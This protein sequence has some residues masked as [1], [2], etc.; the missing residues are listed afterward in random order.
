MQTYIR[1]TRAVLAA[2]L[3]LAAAPPALGQQA[4]IV[5][6]H[7]EKADQ[8]TDTALS[9]AGRARAA[10]L[11]ALL[12]RAGVTAVYAT[13]YRRTVQTVQPL[14]DTLK[15]TVQT[16]P[17]D[18]TA[19]LVARLRSQHASDVVLVAGH[20]NSVPEILARLGHTQAVTIADDDFS[21]LFVVVPRA[22]GAPAVL[23]LS[24]PARAR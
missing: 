10:A 12:A 3:L 15:L 17:A 16:M 7:A 13:Q 4:I 23:R 14:A 8:S 18:D 11:A 24:I 1:R 5:V 2:L 20:S 22:G 6:R 19:G 21:S 9:E